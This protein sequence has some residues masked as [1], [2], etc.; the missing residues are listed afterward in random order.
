QHDEGVRG[1]LQV[2]GREVRSRDRGGKNPEAGL[3][4]SG[5]LALAVPMT[6]LCPMFA[7][8]GRA[9]I[10]Q[11]AKN[12]ANDPYETFADHR[13]TQRLLTKYPVSQAANSCFDDL[14]R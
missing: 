8:G 11:M 3:S 10:G 2:R 1:L 4:N 7:S 14:H 13:F 6:P 5:T 12:D 9:D